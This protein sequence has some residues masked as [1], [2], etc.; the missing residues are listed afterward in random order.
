[1]ERRSGSWRGHALAL[2]RAYLFLVEGGYVPADAVQARAVH[3]ALLALEAV[4]DPNN[5]EIRKQYFADHDLKPEAARR[6]AQRTQKR[7]K[8]AGA[9]IDPDL[10]SLATKLHGGLSGFAHNRRRAVR[11]AVSEP[12]IVFAYGPHPGLEI[13]ASHVSYATSLVVH[14]V[15]V[16][17]ASLGAF[18]GFD[19]TYRNVGEPLV[20]RLAAIDLVHPLG[21]ESTKA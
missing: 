3:E 6:S 11:V 14:L 9:Q 21:P 4:A 8:A 20:A 5:E 2:G 7:A 17:A 19:D 15:L 13:V 10:R 12:P 18:E 16:V 1:M